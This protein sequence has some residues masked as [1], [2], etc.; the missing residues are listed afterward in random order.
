MGVGAQAVGRP[1][2]ANGTL[3]SS[4]SCSA[5]YKTGSE[6]EYKKNK[7]R[8][9]SKDLLS[10]LNQTTRARARAHTHTHTHTHNHTH[11]HTHT[12]YTYN[13]YQAWLQ[14]HLDECRPP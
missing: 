9:D 6:F 12:L 14:E 1:A 13:I 3:T 8:S 11:T 10:G 7:L 4:A 2:G 5:G